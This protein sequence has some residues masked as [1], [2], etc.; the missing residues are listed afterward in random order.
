MEQ[1]VDYRS[2]LS[3]LG[4]RLGGDLRVGGNSLKGSRDQR[5][6]K[7]GA[8]RWAGAGSDLVSQAFVAALTLRAF[9]IVDV[10][11]VAA[12]VMTTLAAA[13][14]VNFL[15]VVGAEQAGG[16]DDDL[17]ASAH[18]ANLGGAFGFRGCFLFGGRFLCGGLHGCCFF[19][20]C[21]AV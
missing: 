4:S 8:S 5:R 15:A 16:S 19:L 21:H 20:C 7:T 10:R 11:S 2:M 3:R 6:W 18:E 9:V 14:L 17:T 13:N 12:I 1:A